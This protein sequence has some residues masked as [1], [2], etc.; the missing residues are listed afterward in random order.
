MKNN[1]LFFR[2]FK[3]DNNLN[4]IKTGQVDIEIKVF[5]KEIIGMELMTPNAIVL[6]SPLKRCLQSV[7]F[8]ESFIRYKFKEIIIVDEL[9]E[10]NYGLWESM[11]KEEIAQKYP[12]YFIDGVFN[13][14][15]TPPDGESYQN[16]LKRVNKAIDLIN[17]FSTDHQ[18]IICSHNHFLKLLVSQLFEL[19]IKID[20]GFKN[21]IIYTKNDIIS[22]NS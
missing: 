10:R 12:G 22:Q 13:Y 19:K 2:H 8:I 21:G 15:L 6:T 11:P 18:L 5:P 17:T 16:I 3:T 9:K 20:F 7:S 1:L 14:L 4:K